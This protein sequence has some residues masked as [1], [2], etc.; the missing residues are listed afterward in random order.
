[1]Y[2]NRTHSRWC[3][4]NVYPYRTLAAKKLQQISYSGNQGGGN[5]RRLSHILKSINNKL[6]TGKAMIARADKGRITIVMYTNEYT[7]KVQT[8]LRGNNFH[9][10]QKDPT[11]RAQRTLQKLLQQSN[12]VIDKRKIK[13]LTQKPPSTHTKRINKTTLPHRTCYKQHHG[14]LLQNSQTPN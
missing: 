10:F 13:F 5:Q 4:R 1:M 12:L 8:F 9:T 7:S 11:K 14:S 6:T 3:I 2:K